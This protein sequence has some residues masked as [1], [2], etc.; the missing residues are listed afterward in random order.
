MSK[1][2]KGAKIIEAEV[3]K[4]SHVK[5]AAALDCS[6]PTIYNLIDGSRPSLTIANRA[7]EVFKIPTEAWESGT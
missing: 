4:T 3:K 2:N 1:T 6:V 7:K 5:V